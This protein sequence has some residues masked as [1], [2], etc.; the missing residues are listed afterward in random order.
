MKTIVIFSGTTEGRLLSELLTSDAV[1]HTVCVASDYGKDMMTESRY[2]DI[3]VGRMN[4][5]EMADYLNTLRCES[6]MIVVDATHPYASEVTSNIKDAADLLGVRYIRVSRKSEAVPGDHINEYSDIGECARSLDRTSGNIL[7]TT[8]SKELPLYCSLVSAKALERTY[9]R[10]LPSPESLGIC[11]E[12]GIAPDHIIAMQGPFSRE[13]N[14]A[15]IRQYSIRHLITKESGAVGGFGEKRDAAAATGVEL[16]V[17]KRPDSEDG[18]SVNDAFRL[19]TGKDIP[20][21][22]ETINISIIGMGMGA[23]ELMT[24]AAKDALENCDAA[25][26]AERLI[27][28]ISCHKKYPMYLASDIIPVLEQEHIGR[29][30]IVFSGDAGFFSGA[31][32]MISALNAWNSDANIQVFPGISSFS[33]LAARLG[34]SYDD[35]ELFSLHGKCSD[36]DL[37]ALI[38]TIRYRKKV[39]VLLS[40]AADISRISKR[41]ND[42]GISCRLYAGANLSYDNE[43]VKELTL[44]EAFEYNEDGLVTA[45]IYNPEPLKRPLIN[46]KKDSDFIRGKVP[47]T[48]E[49]IRH[50][51]IIRLGLCEDDV[52]YD[53][54]AGTGSISIEAAALH[55]GLN[56]YAFEKESTAVGLI[57]QNISGSD[58][59]NVTIVEGDAAETLSD[60]PKPDC[61]FIGGSS[62]R[63][64]EI[65]SI[66]HSKGSGIRFVINAVSLETMQEIS[67]IIREYQPGD[68]ESVMLSVSDVRKAGSHHILQGQN[69][70]WIF[71][72]TL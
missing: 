16:H 9:V 11:F 28:N 29:A 69:P 8:G 51:S 45:F 31:K 33:Y 22:L 35:A 47:M 36:K 60:F 65:I 44:S 27:R 57:R 23:P 25:F 62:G 13:L 26:G 21:N 49:C 14:E 15:V 48:K 53:I 55:P 6:E 19:I 32:A 56:V 18:I 3:H 68:E 72:F 12:N 64:G 34:E 2:A 41:I 46:V 43:Y 4:A 39:F 58:I 52:F 24:V 67:N 38:E 1:H 42:C 63:L 10:V 40:G 66:L 61:V 70:V 54:G 71:S 50:E 37:D 20:C 17:I 5:T 7:L 59:H 30:A